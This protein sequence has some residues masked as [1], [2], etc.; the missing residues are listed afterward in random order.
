M[1]VTEPRFPVEGY[2]RRAWYQSIFRFAQRRT[3]VASVT[4]AYSVPAHVGVVFVDATA[5]A[6]TVTLPLAADWGGRNI[7]V[8]K[9]D[10]SG[11]AVTVGAGTDTVST[12]SLAGQYDKA[13]YVSNGITLWGAF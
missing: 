11:N 3:T 4:T 9:T 2:E 10:A 5:G 12:T 8:M 13:S 1:E 6:V 7:L